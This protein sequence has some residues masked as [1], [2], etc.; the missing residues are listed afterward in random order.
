[1]RYEDSILETINASKEH[2]TAEQ[3]FF[4]LKGRYPAVVMATVYNNLNRLYQQGRIRRISVAGEPDHYDQN[5][6]RHDH[7]VCVKCSRI[8]D[9]MLPDMTKEI[10]AHAKFKVIGYDLKIRYLCPECRAKEELHTDNITEK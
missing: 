3:I 8:E 9:I 10:E 5:F 7:L 4:K 6:T 2:L 1:M